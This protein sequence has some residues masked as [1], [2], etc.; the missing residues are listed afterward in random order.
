VNLNKH[1]E[2]FDPTALNKEVHI[3]GVGAIGSTLA[4]MFTRLGFEELCLYDID[5]VDEHNLTNQMYRFKDI[6]K[7]KLESIKEILTEINPDIK[8]NV[9]NK[10]YRND[11]RLSGYVFLTVDNIELR[12][13]ICMDQLC[14]QNIDY[15]ADFRMEL[16]SAQT[17]A[18]PWQNERLR[19][20]FISTM[21]FTEAEPHQHPSKEEG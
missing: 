4:E 5:T 7:T 9:F 10:G 16:T 15:M 17:Y 18:C 6:G 13:Q 2:F 19:K 11:I 21:N 3:I 14:N 1:Q 8:I 12:K 20:H